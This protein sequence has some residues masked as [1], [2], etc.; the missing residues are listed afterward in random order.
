[1]PGPALAG[2]VA[3]AGDVEHEDLRVDQRGRER[4]GEVVA[5]GLD[6]HQVE[7]REVGLEVLDGEQVR[8]DVVADRGVRA[9]AGLD[10]A[11]PL[12]VEHPGGAQQPGV[13]V[14][15]DVV[16]D[17]ARARARRRARGRAAR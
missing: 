9:G 1:M 16:G 13:L 7:R 12:G 11:D 3:A 4:R 10:G 15:V 5:A 8:G 14:G 2:D 17:D 6:Q